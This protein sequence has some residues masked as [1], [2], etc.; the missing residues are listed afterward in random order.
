MILEPRISASAVLT[1]YSGGTLTLGALPEAISL[2][3]APFYVGEQGDPGESWQET[4]ETVSQNLN[5][6]PATL[7]R[8]AG[9]LSSITFD[10]GG[11]QSITKTLGR[12]AGV[13]TTITLSGDTPSGITLVKTLLRDEAGNVTGYSYGS[14]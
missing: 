13:L 9:V 3:L 14:A 4:F 8:S 2:A 6:Y 1:G 11:G 5:S 7:N 10:L 12:V